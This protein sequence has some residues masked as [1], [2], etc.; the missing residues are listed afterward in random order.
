MLLCKACA[1]SC[2]L[3]ATQGTLSA[4]PLL[5]VHVI[6]ATSYSVHSIWS[7][8][9]LKEQLGA[10]VKYLGYPDDRHY[11][12][13][14]KWRVSAAAK[15]LMWADTCL[16]NTMALTCSLIHAAMSDVDLKLRHGLGAGSYESLLHAA[17]EE[18]GGAF[19]LDFRGGPAPLTR[20]LAGPLLERAIGVI[21]KPATERQSHYFHACATRAIC[22]HTIRLRLTIRASGKLPDAHTTVE[23]HS[24]LIARG[25]ADALHMHA[26][27]TRATYRQT[28]I[29]G[30][31]LAHEAACLMRMSLQSCIS[32]LIAR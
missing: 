25:T 7:K 6:S 21:Y 19:A 24:C 20:E 32:G 23:L 1:Y 15:C 16:C 29:V 9:C 27:T 18:R 17:C 11:P 4:N 31:C 30:A 28:Q 3:N 12:T 26:C 14:G 2:T 13:S 5:H 10:R 22:T 8:Q